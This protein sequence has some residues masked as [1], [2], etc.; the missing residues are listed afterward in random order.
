[1]RTGSSTTEEEDFVEVVRSEFGGADV[2]LDIVGGPYIARNIKAARP[3]G[4][5]IQLAFALGSKVEINLMPVM[6]KRLLYTG[7]TLRSR[8]DAQ[9]AAIAAELREKVWPLVADGTIRPV[10][11]TTLPLAQAGEAH[12]LME[13]AGH[14]GKII[15]RVN[16]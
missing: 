3:D 14:T 10:V 7:S 9:K 4:R 11:S 5:I 16:G 13:S 8:S 1:M 6:L 2:I 12:A 15:L